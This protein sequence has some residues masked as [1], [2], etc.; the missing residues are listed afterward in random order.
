MLAPEK[1]CTMLPQLVIKINRHAS[2][3]IPNLA[4]LDRVCLLFTSLSLPHGGKMTK[5]EYIAIIR[6]KAPA[7]ACCNNPVTTVT[8]K[9]TSGNN[10]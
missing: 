9:G 4:S 3:G 1:I 8:L 10:Q 2:V 6:K 5:I 7:S